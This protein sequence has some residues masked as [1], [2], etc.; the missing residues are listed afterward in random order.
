MT[1]ILSTRNN[2]KRQRRLKFS[3][4]Q[5]S[6]KS[7][8]RG[9]VEIATKSKMKLLPKYLFAILFKS[10]TGLWFSSSVNSKKNDLKIPKA[11]NAS[12]VQSKVKSHTFYGPLK[13]AQY[14]EN[15]VEKR[16]SIMSNAEKYLLIVLSGPIMNLSQTPLCM[17]LVNKDA[18]FA[19]A[20]SCPILEEIY[21]LLEFFT[22]I[23]QMIESFLNFLCQPIL[24]ASGFEMFAELSSFESIF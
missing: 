8:I 5:L 3:G 6:L 19:D 16:A 10:L 24:F 4:S 13:H 18:A 7:P 14:A 2:L 9:R 12:I 23:P 17:F 1:K 21:F 11:K 22:G 15:K 20:S